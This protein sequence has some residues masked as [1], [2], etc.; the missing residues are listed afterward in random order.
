M[1]F[2]LAAGREGYALIAVH[3]LLTA[4]CFSVAEHGFCPLAAGVAVAGSLRV[5]LGR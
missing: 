5:A 2:S 3:R 4:A 1:G